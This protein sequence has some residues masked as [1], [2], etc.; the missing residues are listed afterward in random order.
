[1]GRTADWIESRTGI[2]QVQR[3]APDELIADLALS[4]AIEALMG[5]TGA[6]DLVISATCSGTAGEAT[7]AERVGEVVAPQAA[8]LELNAACAGFCYAVATADALIRVGSAERVLIVAAEQMTRIVDPL[9]LGTS[10]IFG[11]GAGAAVVEATAQPQI[12]PVSWGSD[13]GGADLIM[14]PEGTTT[15]TMQGQQ[16]FRWA[17]ASM[18]EVAERACRLAGV[19]P[20]DIE[21]FVPHQANARIVDALTEKLGLTH[22]LVSRDIVTSGNTSAASIPIA[23]TKLLTAHPEASGR[24]ALL[25]GFG[26]GLSYAAQV[27]RLP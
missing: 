5:A 27:V 18:V 22:A 19:R 16:V 8:R 26:A 6:V 20:R 1:V 2:R 23:V 11:D 3:L 25:V 10:I 13:G 17:V 7:I 21:V 14:I 24:L 15:L 4:A 12:G 9:D